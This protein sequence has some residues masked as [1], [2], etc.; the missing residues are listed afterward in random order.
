ML[1]FIISNKSYLTL[2][3]FLTP[4]NVAELDIAWLF[5]LIIFIFLKR[6]AEWIFVLI[7][8]MIKALL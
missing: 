8:K 6:E 3:V 4:R 2:I 7:S 1:H 5:Y